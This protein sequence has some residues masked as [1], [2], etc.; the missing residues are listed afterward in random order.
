MRRFIKFVLIVLLVAVGAMLVFKYQLFREVSTRKLHLRNLRIGYQPSTHQIAHMIAMKKGWWK[1]DLKKHGIEKVTEYEFPSGPPEMTAMLA[2]EL[3][4]AY[5]GTAP[6]IT[7]IYEGLDA[8]IVAGVQTQGSNLVLR[9]GVNFKGVH[10]LKGLKIATFPPGS[11]QDTILRK[12]LIDNN[13]DPDEDIEI[14]AMGPGD[15]ISALK[16]KAIDGAFLPHPAPAVIELEK[17]GEMAISSGEMWPNHACCC[18]LVRGE[19]IRNNPDL[20]KDIIKV[21]IRAT[22]YAMMYPDEA[23]DIF[24]QKTGWDI[25]KIK[26]SLNTWDGKWISDPHMEIESTLEFAKVIYN[27]TKPRYGHL[28]TKEDIFNTSFYDKIIKENQ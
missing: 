2:G 3:D 22:E 14:I 6:P 15:A 24:A 10:D 16:A 11:I 5:V 4:I 27:L 26:Y 23:A 19:L 13:V 8:K 20:V 28:L 17:S 12:W 1:E 9:P 18:L 25:E 7:A 21:H